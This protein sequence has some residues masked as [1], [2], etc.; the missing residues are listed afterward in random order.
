MSKRFTKLIA[1][2]AATMT[3]LPASAQVM[4]ENQVPLTPSRILPGQKTAQQKVDP[5]KAFPTLLAKTLPRDVKSPFSSPTIAIRPA[6]LKNLVTVNPDLTMWGNLLTNSFMGMYSFHPVANLNFELLSDYKKGYFNGGSG[7]ID[8]VL[9]GIY[10]DTSYAPYGILLLSH[11]AFDTETWQLEEQPKSVRDYSLIATE[12]ATDPTT[13]EVFGEFYT[14]DL[15]NFEWGVID[16]TT[17]T[18]TTIAPAQH[19]YVALGIANDGFAYGVSKEGD[20]YQI[21]RSTGAET[22]K[23]STGVEIADA[24]GQYYTQSGEFDVRTNEFFW[25]STD[26]DGK[27]QLYTVDLGDGHVTPVGGYTEPAMLVALNFPAVATANGAP[28]AASDLKADFA[29]G[30]LSGK[31]SFKAPDKKYDGSSLTGNV[32]YK[33]FAN[34]KEVANGTAEAGKKVEA[35]VT[36]S[37]GVVNF[38]VFY[39]A[40]QIIGKYLLFINYLFINHLS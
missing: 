19:T 27:F 13:G 1:A 11:Y 20:F 15:K 24:K 6:D 30:A 25:A 12:T 36:V 2:F 17:L 40:I 23:G 37:E 29:N 35:N 38:I 4:P 14:A 32:S 31:V 7:M 10:L 39:V 33:V 18:R 22:K 21:D 28:A 3:M 26:K 9:H 16:Y 34:G 8:G 5:L